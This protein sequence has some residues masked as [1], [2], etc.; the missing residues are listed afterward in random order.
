[1]DV[2]N[3]IT[4]I[5]VRFQPGFSYW[6]DLCCVL[7]SSCVKEADFK[8]F[9]EV[10]C[11]INSHTGWPCVLILRAEFSRL[12]LFSERCKGYGV[13]SSSE[14]SY[15]AHTEGWNWNSNHF[16][17]SCWQIRP[18]SLSSSTADLRL[19]FVFA[20]FTDN[21]ISAIWA[22]CR[23]VG[24]WSSALWNASRAG[25]WHTHVHTNAHS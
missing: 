13:Y 21:C 6:N 11:S 20:S 15:S 14:L 16:F 25:M 5:F 22:F 18:T 7:T 1:M 23:L 2:V 10:L 9:S 3:I 12:I 17:S 19:C 8:A 24:I 4:L